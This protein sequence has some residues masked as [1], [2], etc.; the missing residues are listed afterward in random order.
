MG[1]ASPHQY[2][3]RQQDLKP[4]HDNYL[5][6][7]ICIFL[8]VEK[9]QETGNLRI[10]AADKTIAMRM[11]IR[12]AK[13]IVKAQKDKKKTGST[14]KENRPRETGEK[15]IDPLPE[16]AFTIYQLASGSN[17]NDFLHAM[18]LHCVIGFPVSSA[19]NRTVSLP[20]SHG[21]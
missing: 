8:D 20:P 7:G 6:V 11:F 18:Q 4:S 16:N 14:I 9:S 13:H 3:S 5:P 19:F 2:D 12:L 10:A 15:A 1:T 21:I 17:Y